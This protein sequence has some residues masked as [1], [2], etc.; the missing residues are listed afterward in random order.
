MIEDIERFFNNEFQEV[1]RTHNLDSHFKRYDTLPLFKDVITAYQEKYPDL[2]KELITSALYT[3][4]YIILASEIKKPLDDDIRRAE[5]IEFWLHL[6]YQDF[7]KWKLLTHIVAFIYR[8]SSILRKRYYFQ[9]DKGIPKEIAATRIAS[10][11]LYPLT[12]YIRDKLQEI[13]SYWASI[14]IETA[15][16]QTIFSEVINRRKEVASNKGEELT[17]E[18]LNT[19]PY[20]IAILAKEQLIGEVNTIV[21]VPYIDNATI[22][23]YYS[24]IKNGKEHRLFSSNISSPELNSI[25][26]KSFEES[27]PYL[28]Q[29]YKSPH[30]LKYGR[31]QCK[32]KEKSPYN[33]FLVNTTSG[34][35]EGWIIIYSSI[36]DIN[37]EK[38]EKLLKVK[39]NSLE[40]LMNQSQTKKG[41]FLSKLLK[42]F[43]KKDN[44]KLNFWLDIFLKEML[45]DSVSGIELIDIYDSYREDNFTITALIE[46]NNRKSPPTTFIS[47]ANI[48]Y[49][50]ELLDPMISFLT[51]AEELIKLIKNPSVGDLTIIPEEAFYLDKEQNIPRILEFVSDGTTLI[52]VLADKFI[53]ASQLS[54]KEEEVYK[55]RTITRKA[56]ELL[57]VFNSRKQTTLKDAG[58]RILPKDINWK[59]IKTSVENKALY[60]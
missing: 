13:P 17:I 46:S 28:S 43:K 19:N 42:F 34:N 14:L 18:Q 15:L 4:D 38:M 25:V 10:Y 51:F 12:E 54:S 26:K 57:G 39:I 44:D 1:Q 24:I 45:I 11:F 53:K 7:H 6:P 60:Y 48:S 22:I 27:K 50:R 59:E 9:L 21:P 33:I 52:G 40:M 47:E 30:L 31:L 8:I 5:I 23:Q 16:F 32:I 2:S 37:M 55:R 58:E 29:N 35:S 56:R 49:P 36:D 41:G 20:E 3:S